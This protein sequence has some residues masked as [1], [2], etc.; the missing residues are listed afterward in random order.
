MRILNKNTNRSRFGGY[1]LFIFEFRNQEEFDAYLDSL[2]YCVDKMLEPR[3]MEILNDTADKLEQRCDS[4][5]AHDD[6][7]LSTSLFPDE[8]A[9][10]M[11]SMTGIMWMYED[12][13]K[14]L[15][16]VFAE[17]DALEQ[18]DEDDARIHR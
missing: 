5:Y 3:A 8:M 6:T 17:L 13:S 4:R 16:D 2:R 11:M 14:M 9:R 7:D 18:P 10:F 12:F 1:H 15:D